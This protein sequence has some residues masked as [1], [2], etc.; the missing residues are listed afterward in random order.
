MYNRYVCNIYI[1]IYTCTP[2]VSLSLSIY[3]YTHIHRI[4]FLFGNE[5]PFV[6]INVGGQ[7]NDMGINAIDP[8]V[9]LGI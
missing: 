5:Y 9:V 4:I 7:L 6:L 3:I 2:V 8:I 1:Y